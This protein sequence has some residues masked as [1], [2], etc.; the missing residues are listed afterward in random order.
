MQHVELM[1]LYRDVDDVTA[2]EKQDRIELHQS[3]TNGTYNYLLSYPVSTR[4][5][6]IAKTANVSQKP[7][8]TK[9]AKIILPTNL[10]WE[11]PMNNA[12]CI[13]IPPK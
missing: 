3:S 1:V 13:T 4:T 6:L 5:L 9:Q 10:P 2:Q 11:N 7:L 12:N 8:V